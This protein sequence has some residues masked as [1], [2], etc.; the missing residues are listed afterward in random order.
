MRH[1]TALLAG[2]ALIHVAATAADIG[3]AF[4]GSPEH[5]AIEYY[6]RPVDDPVST[7]NR[8]IQDGKVQLKFDRVNGYLQSVLDALQIHTESQLMVFSKTSLMKPLISPRNPRSIF[9]NDS[10]ALA[11]VRG[12]PFLEIATQ[13]RRQGVIF[14]TLDQDLA[15]KPTFKRRD[16]CLT[17]HLSHS[18]LGVPGMLVRSVHTEPG[19]QTRRDL[20]DYITDHRSP[21]EERFG[22]WYVTGKIASV[23]HL[24]NA[25]VTDSSKPESTITAETLSLKSLDGKFDP[26]AYLSSH[27]DIAALMVFDHQMH[28][29]NLLTR[30][31][32]EIR[33]AT[34][35]K[36]PLPLD[37]LAR[38]VVDYLLFVDEPPLA[39]KVEGA[40]GFAQKFAAEGPT[41]RKGR[42]LRQLDLNHRLVRYPCSY[43]I[44]TEAFDGLPAEAKDAIYKR[45]WRILAGMETGEKYA[46]LSP[47]DRQAIVEI[48]RDTKKGLPAY[49]QAVK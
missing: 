4:R 15:D 5:P 36:R 45:M 7:L 38:A 25:M 48:L 12:E 11:W 42:S 19:G 27:S 2:A 43:M 17:C 40:S 23:R 8:K 39:G 20:G 21:M 3:G 33:L 1:W 24:G 35:E 14:Y 29:T 28:M 47:S 22:G 9:F 18:S 44:Y 41:D 30:L 31:G 34:H 16:D 13:D 10:V 37:D 49:L 6:S 26:Y 46:R 32:W